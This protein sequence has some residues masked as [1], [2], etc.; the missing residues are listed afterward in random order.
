MAQK[1]ICICADFLQQQSAEGG[2]FLAHASGFR[3]VLPDF[4]FD[5]LFQRLAG[6]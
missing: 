1:L 4:E 2:L 3:I 6:C 5:L